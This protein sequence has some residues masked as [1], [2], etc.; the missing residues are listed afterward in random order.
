VL[1]KQWAVHR[2]AQL[3]TGWPRMLRA[4]AWV[5]VALGID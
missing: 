4:A 1:L 2:R 5:R 3:D